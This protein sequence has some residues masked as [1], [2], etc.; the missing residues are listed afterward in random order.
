M[1]STQKNQMLLMRIVFIQLLIVWILL[2]NGASSGAQQVG[3]EFASTEVVELTNSY[4]DLVALTLSTPMSG[5]VV[6]TGSGYLNMYYEG[7]TG[8]T[9]M[10]IGPISGAS[11]N[12]NETAVEIP[13]GSVIGTYIFPFSITAV[14][15]VSRGSHNFYMVGIRDP[16]QISFSYS[17]ISLKLT[18]L[19]VQRRM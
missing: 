2:G 4:Q 18:A 11:N 1:R 16:N 12:E 17:A 10:S 3:I 9:T 19:F 14:I 5:Y 15:P 6:L 13:A 7:G 8:W